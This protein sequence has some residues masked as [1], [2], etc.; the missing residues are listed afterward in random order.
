MAIQAVKTIEPKSNTRRN[1]PTGVT[2]LIGA[3]AGIGAR[4]IMPT[5]AELSKAI[6][7]DVV[8]SFTS[9]A[10]MAARSA[11]RSAVQY[12]TLGAF[13]A[14]SAKALYDIFTK[15]SNRDVQ[16]SKLGALIDAPDYA[17]EMLWYND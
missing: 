4:Y 2:A 9:S 5:K 1:I 16:Y 13:F 3:T 12:G 10:A 14:V 6:N 11:K 17:C 8:D 7:K 15:K